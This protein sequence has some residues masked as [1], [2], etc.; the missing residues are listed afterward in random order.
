MSGFSAVKFVGTAYD[1]SEN[2]IFYKVRKR[3]HNIKYEIL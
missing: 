2:A 1:L 3:T